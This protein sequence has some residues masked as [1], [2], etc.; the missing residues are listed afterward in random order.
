MPEEP[1]GGRTWRIVD[2]IEDGTALAGAAMMI[3]G[4]WELSH[5][6]ALIV[7]GAMLLSAATK[8]ATRKANR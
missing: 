2:L 6:A 7:F 8:S 5:P 3:Y 1:N 4:A